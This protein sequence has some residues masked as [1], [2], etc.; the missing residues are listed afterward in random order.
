MDELLNKEFNKI[1]KLPQ[2]QYDLTR[3]L[4]ELVV[5]G[6]RLGLYDASDFIMRSLEA[7]ALKSRNGEQ[8]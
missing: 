6:N 2:A 1:K 7:K 5:I 8:L 4:H 3:Q